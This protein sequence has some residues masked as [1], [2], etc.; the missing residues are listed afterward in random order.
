MHNEDF[1][2]E[3]QEWYSFVSTY[4]FVPPSYT[5]KFMGSRA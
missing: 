2:K 1:T 4:S 3:Q 5:Q